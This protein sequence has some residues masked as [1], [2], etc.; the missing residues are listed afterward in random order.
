[1]ELEVTAHNSVGISNDACSF[2]ANHP[3]PASIAS[4]KTFLIDTSHKTIVSA[5]TFFDD[6]KLFPESICNELFTNVPT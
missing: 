2:V 5:A 1:M 4:E 6:V 3:D